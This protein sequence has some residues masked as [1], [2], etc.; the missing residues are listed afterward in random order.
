M[1]PSLKVFAK[2]VE[3]RWLFG[4]D[5]AHFGR[6]TNFMSRSRSEFYNTIEYIGLRPQKPKRRNFFG[7]W[8]IILIAL[9]MGFWFGKPLIPFLK[10]AQAAPST[11][12]A[13]LLIS[14]LKSSNDFQDGLAAAALA[15]TADN[16]T[17][18]LAYFKIAYPNGDV[19]ANKGVAADVV[20]RSFRAMKMDLQVMV[21]E[22]MAANFRLYPQLWGASAPDTNI[23]HRRV[24]NLQR[25]F[26]RKGETLTTSRNPADYQPGDIVIWSLA[27]A[28]SHIGI[29]VPGPGDHANEPWV[30][31]NIGLGVKWENILFDYSIQRHFR[32]S[33]EDSK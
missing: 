23:D 1:R 12:Q 10:A 4:R 21:H 30:V 9:A 27:N 7:G 25:F 19:P 26:E 32:F 14:S 22:D 31:H 13:D 24:P 18:D 16:V 11:E 15:H 17:Y 6:Q 8:V 28:E 33:P 5:F 29:I 2:R 3:I 20:I